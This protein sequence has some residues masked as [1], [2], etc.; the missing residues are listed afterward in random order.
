MVLLV[1][2]VTEAIDA[3]LMLP[4]VPGNQF[5]VPIM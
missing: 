5:G 1:P 3:G 2:S 4:S